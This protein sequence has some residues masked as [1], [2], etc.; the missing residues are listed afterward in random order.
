MSQE[1]LIGVLA[2]LH[3]E[4]QHVRET[5][6]KLEK[7][8]VGSAEERQHLVERLRELLV[9]HMAG[10]E[11]IFYPAV[12]DA[13]E[14]ADEASTVVEGYE[15]HTHAK[16]AL[17]RFVAADPEDPEWEARLSVLKELVTHHIDEEEEDLFDLAHETLG[18][19]GLYDLEVR[20]QAKRKKTLEAMG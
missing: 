12:R 4:H 13:V 9:P 8:E 20:Y 14:D 7:T 15:E 17:E 6:E 18:E 10:E 16:T 5:F 2:T 11:E 19:D 3:K 1:N